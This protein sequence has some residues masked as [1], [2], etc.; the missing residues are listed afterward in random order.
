MGREEEV[1][2]QSGR[3]LFMEKEKNG[4]GENWFEKFRVQRHVRVEDT[5]V[6]ASF[7]C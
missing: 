3:F 2:R 1:E 6:A 5:K 4:R 7:A